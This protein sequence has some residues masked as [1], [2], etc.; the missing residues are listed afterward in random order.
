[1]WL[2]SLGAAFAFAWA[3]RH[4]P[5]HLS[6]PWHL[7]HWL[8]LRALSASCPLPS[9]GVVCVSPYATVPCWWSYLLFLILL[10][11]SL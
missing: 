6:V 5:S 8:A 1:M 3:G 4:S 10:Y 2:F 9:S 7:F 11:A